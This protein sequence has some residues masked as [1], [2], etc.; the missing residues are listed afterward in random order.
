MYR[1]T[2]PMPP[3]L[4]SKL[5]SKDLLQKFGPMLISVLKFKRKDTHTSSELRLEI[6]Y[7]ASME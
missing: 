6:N 3:T 7:K 1:P 4:F 2:R 5:V